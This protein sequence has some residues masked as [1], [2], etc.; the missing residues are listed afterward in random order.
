MP[1]G[2]TTKRCVNLPQ[3]GMLVKPFFQTNVFIMIV[4]DLLRFGQNFLGYMYSR[5]RQAQILDTGNPSAMS[6]SVMSASAM[7]SGRMAQDR[8]TQG[9]TARKS[10][11][12]IL[13]FYNEN[14]PADSAMAAEG[15]DGRERFI[16]PDSNIK[17]SVSKAQYSILMFTD[18]H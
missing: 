5:R 2:F 8:M 14:E 15:C 11:R 17:Y 13:S 6:P 1:P 7:S 4:I 9:R 3:C 12:G 10:D 18:K 16:D